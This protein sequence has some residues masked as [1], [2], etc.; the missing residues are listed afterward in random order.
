MKS[1]EVLLGFGE[2][3]RGLALI[4]EA[5]TEIGGFVWQGIASFSIANGSVAFFSSLESSL[6]HSF[7]IEITK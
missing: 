6:V 4:I 3:L 2:N 7:F 1:I 5:G